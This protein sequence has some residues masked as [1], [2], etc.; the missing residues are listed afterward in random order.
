[1]WLDGRTAGS[2]RGEAKQAVGITF[3]PR[4]DGASRAETGPNLQKLENSDAPRLQYTVGIIVSGYYT[5][6]AT[7]EDVVVDVAQPLTSNFIT[8]GGNIVLALPAGAGAASPGTKANFGFNVKYNKPGTNLQGGANVIVRSG[9][10]VYQVKS[11]AI[12]SLGVAA[13]NANFTAK[14]NVTDVTDPL[15]PVAI[16]GGTIQLR[17]TDNGEPGSADTIGIQVFT[18]DG[19]LWFSSNWDGVRTVEQ[20]LGGGNLSVH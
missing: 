12:L 3:E 1:M 13:P 10:R 20:L 2:T 9:G 7:A 6:N 14:A 4:V 8:G 5:R 18:K 16:D 17:L 11:N 15:A 19:T